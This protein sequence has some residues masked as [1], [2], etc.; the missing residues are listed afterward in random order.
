[1]IRGPGRKLLEG[2]RPWEAGQ[3]ASG[4]RTG[5]SGATS[6]QGARR[7]RNRGGQHG[8]GDEPD[9]WV[10]PGSEGE[11]Q[12]GRE[13]AAREGSAGRWLAEGWAARAGWAGVEEWRARGLK[14]WRV[15]WAA[16]EGRGRSGLGLLGWAGVLFSFPFLFLFYFSF[17]FLI[18]TKFEFKY[19]FEFKPHSNKSMHQHECTTNLNLC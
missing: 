4:A 9:L 3:W 18:Q 10:R 8:E 1:V 6:S 5:R 16:R 2:E 12:H 14:G 7:D 11:R 15:G 19:E 17:L 13:R